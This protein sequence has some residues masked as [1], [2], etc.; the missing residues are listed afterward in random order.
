MTSTA[1]PTFRER[2]YRWWTNEADRMAEYGQRDLEQ[3][4]RR[5]ASTWVYG[6]T[7]TLLEEAAPC[8]TT[9]TP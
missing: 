1:E 5:H 8:M 7:V 3:L 9:Q 6:G 4:C 2:Q